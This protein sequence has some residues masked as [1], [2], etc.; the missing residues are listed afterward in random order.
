MAVKR[1]LGRGLD[2]LF[3]VNDLP[4]A[5]INAG[6]A[7]TL[8]LNEIEPNR[9]QP[10]KSFDEGA[11]RELA[12]SIREHGVL[13][14]LLVRPRAEG[15]YQLVAGE[16][17]YRAARLAGLTQVPVVI[18]ELNDSQAMAAALIENL[19]REDLNPIEEALGYKELL[20]QLELTQE[21]VAK[22]VGKSRSAVANSLRLLEMDFPIVTAL[23]EGQITAGHARALAMFPEDNATRA[24]ALRGAIQGTSVRQLERM[25]Q[26]ACKENI[27]KF[28]PK[29]AK[30]QRRRE[31]FFDEVE[32]SLN[33][34]LGRKI[35]VRGTTFAKPGVLEVPFESREELEA[36]AQLLEQ[37]ASKA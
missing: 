24:E 6:E 36:L 4:G 7:G 26:E 20:T 9:G 8:A 35:R 17:R 2:A 37:F 13:Q 28:L 30:P 22:S 34:G 14:P 18:R 25:A 12:D 10:R 3:A 27:S 19:Q 31:S 5:D 16:R 11:L 21:Q 32:L 23:R 29:E 33:E 1:G 15:G